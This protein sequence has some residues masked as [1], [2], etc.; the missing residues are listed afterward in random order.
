MNSIEHKRA[1]SKAIAVL[2]LTISALFSIQSAYAGTVI[3]SPGATCF[4]DYETSRW[5]QVFYNNY[6]WGAF[7]WDDR[8]DL[9]WNNGRTHNN[10]LHAVSAHDPSWASG[11]SVLLYR[12]QWLTWRNTVSSNFWTTGGCEFRR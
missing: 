3:C 9:F 7:G 11:L 6:D 1:F 4:K 2:G 10:C 8:A 5:G 12:G